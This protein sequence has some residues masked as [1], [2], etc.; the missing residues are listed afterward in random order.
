[1]IT[2]N[3]S[4]QE[5]LDYLNKQEFEN[6]VKVHKEEH[7]VVVGNGKKIQMGLNEAVG[8]LYDM[9]VQDR[10][11]MNGN[12]DKIDKIYEDTTILRDAGTF[13][14]LARKHKFIFGGGF[15]G[16]VATILR[17]WIG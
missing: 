12:K 14:K 5:T 11:I 13:I 10:I 16:A 8:A 1:M 7:T 2:R 6:F 17:I 4:L 3:P 15:I 9:R